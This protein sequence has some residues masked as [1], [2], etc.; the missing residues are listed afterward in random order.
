MEHARKGE[1]QRK[2]FPKWVVIL[3]GIVEAIFIYQHV[4]EANHP[5]IITATGN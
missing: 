5:C 4:H 1:N 2:A 3:L